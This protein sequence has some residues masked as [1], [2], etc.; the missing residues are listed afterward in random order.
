MS[1]TDG[2]RH[3]RLP[4]RVDLGLGYVVQVVLV[5]QAILQEI[6]G[7]EEGNNGALDG[8][9]DPDKRII[10]VD[11]RCSSKRRREVFWHELLHA[12]NDI[13]DTDKQ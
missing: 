12:I 4:R 9:W 7:D 8:L 11:K 13:A 6:V 10:Y 5:P 2:E 1:P 3:H